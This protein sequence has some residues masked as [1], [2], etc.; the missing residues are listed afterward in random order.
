M[1]S[2][3]TGEYEVGVVFSANPTKA[4]AYLPWSSIKWQRTHNESSAAEFTI[5]GLDGGIECCGQF[6]GL[7]CWDH[8]LV[9][10]RN[11]YRVWDG[12]IIGW[13][14]G[15]NGD[16]VV[17]AVDRS[18]FMKKTLAGTMYAAVGTLTMQ[19]AITAILGTADLDQSPWSLGID[20]SF[21]TNFTTPLAPEL[22]LRAERLDTLATAFDT[23]AQ[24]TPLYWSCRGDL[25]QMCEYKLRGGLTLPAVSGTHRLGYDNNWLVLNEAT[26]MDIPSV[27]VDG[28]DMATDPRVGGATEGSNGHAFVSVVDLRS[29]AWYIANGPPPPYITSVL[30]RGVSNLSQADEASIEA[31]AEK[32]AVEV[33]TPNTTIEQVALSPEFG[34]QALLSSL[35]NLMPGARL[36][37][38][39]IETCAFSVPVSRS[40]WVNDDVLAW[41]GFV[42]HVRLDQLDVDVQATDDGIK[43][44][45]KASLSATV[46]VLGAPVSVVDADGV[47]RTMTPVY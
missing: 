27:N 2:L 31:A 11:G 10:E 22:D 6:G 17:R 28:T 12:P 15:D 37:L 43:E 34:G 19:A 5:P 8:M 14:R 18:I 47:T 26:V 44:D 32:L 25:L 33:S 23:L 1:A 21:E 20:A 16:V 42:E 4:I 24:S 7:R 29:V 40:V 39:F 9:V 13:N 45:V 36:R 41:S 3:G 38:D 46:E 30:Q 35:D